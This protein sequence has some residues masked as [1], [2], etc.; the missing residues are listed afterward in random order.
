M[1]LPEAVVQELD[2]LVEEG[3]FGS[4]SDA[5]RY[6]ARLVTREARVRR[7]HEVTEDSAK[8]DVAERLKRKRVP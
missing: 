5:L 4:R 1:S 6:G 8:V 7:L 2:R 3:H